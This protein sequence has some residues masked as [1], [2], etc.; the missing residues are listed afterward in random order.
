MQGLSLDLYYQFTNTKEEDLRSQME[1]EAY[2]NVLYR[3]MLEKISEEEEIK[4][5]KKE[6]DA[7]VDEL[8]EN[9]GMKKEDF[10]SNFGGTDMIEYDLKIRKTIDALKELNK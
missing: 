4:V 6:V 8:S 3:L 10:L 9:F 7:H 5:S 1:K 2:R